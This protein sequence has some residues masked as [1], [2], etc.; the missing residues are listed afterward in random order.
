MRNLAT[1][2]VAGSILLL[3]SQSFAFGVQV[4]E[5]PTDDLQLTV[6]AIQSARQS[7]LLNIYE[8]TSPQI[9]DALI[10]RIRSGVHV[11][12]IEEGQPVGGLSAAA[13]GIQTQ[14]VQ[15]MR[16]QSGDHLFEMT[17]KAGNSR[18]FRFDHA[19]YAVI[20]GTSLL[21]GSENYSP[22]GNPE[23]GAQGNR[24]WEV[25][26]H[27]AG[28]AQQFKDMFESDADLSRGDLLDLVESAGKSLP[29]TQLAR[30]SN[31]PSTVTNSALPVL[32]AA[33]V[34]K[35]T[36]PDTSV[37]GVLA[38][39][40]RA[41]SSIDIEQMTFDSAWAGAAQSP[42]VDAV[43]AAARRGVRVRVLLNDERVFDHPGHPSKPKNQTT[44][45]LF[46][47]IASREHLALSA[48]VANLK[49]MGVD[50]IHNKGLLVDG[51]WT[52]ISSI[53]WD[54]NSFEHNRE[55]A[56]LINSPEV[57]AHYEAL[58]E[59]DW[60][61]SG[62]AFEMALRSSAADDEACP[63]EV[64]LTIRIAPLKL[65][66]A[67][68]KDFNSISGKVIEGIFIRSKDS[69][70]CVLLDQATLN[71]TSKRVYLQIRK[72]REGGQN[73]VLEGYT[74][75]S[76]KLYSV[77][78]RVRP[79]ETVAGMHDAIVYDG[80]GPSREQLGTAEM[81]LTPSPTHD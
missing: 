64:R 52:L 45:D 17:S 35:V 31:P 71:E 44:I 34:E 11:E 10:N 1:G 76:K 23:S 68:D 6:S 57:H 67:E 37:S 9:A 18:R 47:Q 54:E 65:V 19:K 80:S 59:R 50:Y 43:L 5:A 61:V 7:L 53:N 27:E 38:A 73:I 15:S 49:A 79:G 48:K 78:S 14:L 40:N 28:I 20:D 63:N 56:V 60:Q 75:V 12:I 62:N 24:G 58:F 77:R 29:L 72:S 66:D 2:L 81:D 41:R 55:A 22:T 33:S 36:S 16:T 26:I 70:A 51:D 8:L 69:S 3:G 21:V 30:G 25:F 46:N 74:L 32:N 42:L 13:R 4:S 39:L